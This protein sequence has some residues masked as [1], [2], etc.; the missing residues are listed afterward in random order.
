MRSLII[1]FGKM[2]L[3]N[4]LVVFSLAFSVLPALANAPNAEVGFEFEGFQTLNSATVV[5]T[6]YTGECPGSQ[7]ETVKARFLSST[8]PPAPGLRVI[9][10]NV[11]RGFGGDSAP[12][13][14]RLIKNHRILLTK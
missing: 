13:T 9:I 5:S 11:S 6:E 7:R 14:V 3:F 1:L 2:T 4:Q 12:N 8:T 10:R